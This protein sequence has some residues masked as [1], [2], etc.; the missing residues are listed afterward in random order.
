MLLV[1]S[2]PSGPYTLS[3]SSSQGSLSSEGKDLMETPHLE[4]PNENLLYGRTKVS[5][6]G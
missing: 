4:I 6:Y 2:V 1:S 3:D 5:T